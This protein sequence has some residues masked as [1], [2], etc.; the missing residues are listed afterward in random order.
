MLLK[1]FVDEHRVFHLI[2]LLK[3]QDIDSTLFSTKTFYFSRIVYAQIEY[4]DI[5]SQ[6]VRSICTQHTSTR[7]RVSL[8]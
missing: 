1:P 2:H 8:H 7:R 3:S 6:L 5:Y 4:G